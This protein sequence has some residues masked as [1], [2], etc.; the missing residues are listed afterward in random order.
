MWI[1][2][3]DGGLN[4]FNLKTGKIERWKHDPQNPH[5]LSANHIL[6]LYFDRSGTLWCGTYGAGVNR[7][8]PG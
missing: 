5:S 3:K 6:S 7:F 4:R 8:E 1:G 2:T